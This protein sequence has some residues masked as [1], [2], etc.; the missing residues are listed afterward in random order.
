M[1]KWRKS[2]VVLLTGCLLLTACTSR[3]SNSMN[4]AAVPSNENQENGQVLTV[5]SPS[6]TT[7]TENENAKQA[8]QKYQ[9]Q[10]RLTDFQ[11]LSGKTGISWGTTRGEL[12]LYMTRDYGVTWRNISPAA[13]VQ[14]PETVHYGQDIFFL[15]EKDGWIVRKSQGNTESILLRTNDGG[16]NWKIYTFTDDITPEAIH[17]ITAERGWLMST[18]QDDQDHQVKS[19]YLTSD[20]GTNWVKAGGEEQTA[21]EPAKQGGLPDIGRF[22]SMAFTTEDEGNILLEDQGILS[23]YKSSDG[24]KKWSSNSLPS[25]GLSAPQSFFTEGPI[26]FFT[27]AG[28]E[29]LNGFIALA[30]IQGKDSGYAA[31]FTEDGAASFHAISFALPGQVPEGDKRVLPV[32]INPQEGWILQGSTLYHTVN[33]GKNWLAL[34]QSQKLIETMQEY[35]EVVKLQFINA[36]LGWILVQNS[37]KNSS[38]LLQTQDGGVSW[39]ML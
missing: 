12:R 24:G 33:Q 10:T 38:R 36:N 31:Y 2:T 23:L 32:F 28:G 27:E 19:L 15:N 17:F 6:N 21:K 8:E 7:S 22:L 13:T 37:A 5:I 35:P 16:L 1:K 18:D 3:S 34:A 39:Q 4:S 11:L 9:I 30:G 26:T 14:F 25:S 29:T 20:G